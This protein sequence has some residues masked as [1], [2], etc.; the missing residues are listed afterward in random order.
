M[1]ILDKK[2]VNISIAAPKEKG[3]PSL[4]SNNPSIVT[5]GSNYFEELWAKAADNLRPS[6]SVDS[7]VA[8]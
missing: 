1:S 2:E 8:I 4:W 3:L 5:I 6:A 7:P